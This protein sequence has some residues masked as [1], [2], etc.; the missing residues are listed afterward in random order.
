MADERPPDERSTEFLP[1]QAPGPEPEVGAPPRRAHGEKP[2]GLVQEMIH[3][4]PSVPRPKMSR[5]STFQ[6]RT[7]QRG[8]WLS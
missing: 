2:A 3:M 7:R 4:A 6:M 8:P 5:R 1:P